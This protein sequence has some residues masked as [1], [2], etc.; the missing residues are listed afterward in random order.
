MGEKLYVERCVWFDNEM[1]SGRFPNAA[2]MADRFE[3]SHKT[4]QRTIDYL[5]DRLHA[6]IEYRPDRRGY[7]LLVPDFHLP[8]ISLTESELTA[9][10]ASRKLLSDAASGPIGEELDRISGKLGA[11][12]KKTLPGAINPEQAFS[13]RWNGFSPSDPLIFRLLVN[14]LAHCL[15]FSFCYYSPLTRACTMRTVE[16]HHMVNYMGDWHLIAFCRLR[17]EWRDFH[18]SRISICKLEN[19]P[20]TPRPQEEW[21]PFLENT[22]GIFQNRECFTVAL[23]FSPERSRWI[24]QQVWHPDQS[25]EKLDNGGL[26]LTIP[27]SHEAEILMEIL[28]HGSH[29]EIEE[30]EWLREKVREEIHRMKKIYEVGHEMGEVRE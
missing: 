29:V 26:R 23:R 4:A 20:F 6:P 14:A 17:E 11:L 21:R 5:R 25:V 8:F 22:F 24:R 10:L 27:V 16:P 3:I 7:A 15:P 28:K 2:S 13:L 30:P 9:L 1:R 18:I 19:E 12:L